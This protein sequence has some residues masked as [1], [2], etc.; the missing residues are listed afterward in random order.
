MCY[1]LSQFLSG[2]LKTSLKTGKQHFPLA[3]ERKQRMLFSMVHTKILVLGL[4]CLNCLP[5]F[6]FWTGEIVCAFVLLWT[7]PCLGLVKLPRAQLKDKRL[8]VHLLQWHSRIL[9]DHQCWSGASTK[10]RSCQ[11]R[12]AQEEN[13]P[14]YQADLKLWGVREAILKYQNVSFW[15]KRQSKQSL[16]S[17][18]S[19]LK[20]NSAPYSDLKCKYF[21]VWIF[22]W[23]RNFELNSTSIT[24]WQKSPVPLILLFITEKC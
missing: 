15:L 10:G 9:M 24:A 11:E 2:N 7:L 20:R 8:E 1:L 17:P 22:F 13:I 4:K 3:L 12:G 6:S 21:H 14:S 19:E 5:V 18:V 16:T 23:P